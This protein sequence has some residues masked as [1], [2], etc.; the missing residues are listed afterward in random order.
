MKK[1]NNQIKFMFAIM[2]AI[3][4]CTIF[5]IVAVKKKGMS[6]VSKNS[7]Y[8]A[9]GDSIPNGYT[10]SEEDTLKSYPKLLAE[11]MKKEE[12][13]SVNLLKY[14]K[15]GITVNGMYE[16][17]LSSAEVQGDLKKADLITVTIGANDILTKFRK[18]YQE[19]FDADRKARDIGTILETIQKKTADDPRILAEAAGII[20]GWDCDDFEKD[21]KM[22][23]KSIRQNRS[24]S[25]RVIVTT[26]YNPVGNLESLGAL[27]QVIE[28][29][30]DRMNRIIADNSEVYGYRT[31]D[32]S[33]V[34]TSEY[35]Q[36]DGLHPNQKGQQMIMAGIKEQR[37]GE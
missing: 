27:N 12:G 2:A 37:S 1:T 31:A 18:L 21:W 19:V 10:V 29:M 36:S 33:G 28:K 22:A 5:M 35:L 20:Y 14:T 6:E 13:I 11:D 9:L 34:G 15:N 4:A 24:E 32:L 23:M 3:C 25:A 26:I 30:I 7:E 16:E 17:Y 8:I